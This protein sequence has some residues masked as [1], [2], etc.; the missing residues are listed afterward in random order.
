MDIAAI[1]DQAFAEAKQKA[2]AWLACK[3]GCDS[4]CRKPFAITQSD[5]IRLREALML[6]PRDVAEDIAQRARDAWSIMRDDFPGDLTTG[7]FDANDEWRE[8]FF[9]RHDGLACP[10]LDLSTGA[11]RLYEARPV[12]CRL[13][14]ALITIGAQTSDPCPLCFEGASA[15]Q[16]ESTRL[17]VA[18]PER[19]APQAAE[20]VIAF[21]LRPTQESV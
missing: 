4:C 20:T 6:A 16:I 11:C 14:G 8:W 19:E 1:A 2:G 3:P 5:A 7:T 15:G 18:L 13:Y 12:C 21:A 9:R 17:V 10:V